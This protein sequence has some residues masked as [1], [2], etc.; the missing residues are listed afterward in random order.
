MLAGIVLGALEAVP[1]DVFVRGIAD[2]VA[3]LLVAFAVSYPLYAAKGIKA[4]DGKLLMA[5]GALRGVNFLLFAAV[6]GALIGGVIAAAF[7]VARRV[8][9]P[10]AGAPPNTMARLLK[11]WIPYGV[12]LGLGALVALALETAGLVRVTLL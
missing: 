8:A 5:V 9:R 6:Y 12:A 3:G 10:A 2:H 4:G 11:T 7:I 1:G